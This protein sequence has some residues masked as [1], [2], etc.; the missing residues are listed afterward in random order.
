MREA[1]LSADCFFSVCLL[2]LADLLVNG[3]AAREALGGVV[4]VVDPVLSQL[5]AKQHDVA[6]NFAG[7]VEQS[8]IKVFYLDTGRVNLSQ[9]VFHARDSLFPLSF[10]ARHMD[11]IDQQAA[12]QKN[13]VR[14]FLELGVNGL[15]KFL[16]VNR[17]AQQRLQYRQ[18]RLGF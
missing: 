5:P 14:E 1:S 8:D 2:R 10:A 17:G 6:I 18:K 4:P 13:A 9:R 15:D 16:A 12:L 7:K 11:Y 3:L